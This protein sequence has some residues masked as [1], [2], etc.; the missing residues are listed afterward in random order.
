MVYFIQEDIGREH[1]LVKIGYSG[2][3]RS[4]ESRRATLQVGN[5][6]PLVVRGRLEHCGYKTEKWLH[7]RF[8]AYKLMG[9][10][11]QPCPGLEA[12]MVWSRTHSF[13]DHVSVEN[14]VTEL[15]LRP[16]PRK[17]TKRVAGRNALTRARE[18]GTLLETMLHI[19]AQDI[20]TRGDPKGVMLP[21]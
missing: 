6:R 8:K 18:K 17:L 3:G 7:M 4:V 15:S 11:F 16:V 14:I 19:A 9:E 2:A 5:G 21:L 1:G 20:V 12:L 10:W 13:A